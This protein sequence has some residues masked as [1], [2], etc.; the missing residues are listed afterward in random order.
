M[1]THSQID[2]HEIEFKGNKWIYTDTGKEIENQRPCGNCGGTHK[3]VMVLVHEDQSH[4]EKGRYDWKNIDACISNLVKALAEA[5]IIMRASCCGH[6]K[7][8]GY[9]ILD[10]G[11]VLGIFE[12]DGEYFERCGSPI[13]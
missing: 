11:R 9:I 10:D 7:K 2:G 5:G 6:G 8:P 3:R 4:T 13:Q 12:N 1:T